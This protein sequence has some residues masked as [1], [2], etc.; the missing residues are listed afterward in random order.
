M[1]NPLFVLYYIYYNTAKG[2]YAMSNPSP[3]TY[4][5]VPF[6][7]DDFSTLLAFMTPLW[8]QTYQSILPEKQIDFLIEKYFTPSAIEDYVKQGYEYYKF[9]D[10]N[11]RTAGVLV[12]VEKAEHTFMDKLYLLPNAR[13]KGLPTQAFALMAKRGKDILL[14]VNRANERAFC[15]YRKN[16]FTV[17][18]ETQVPLKNGMVNLDY[19]MRKKV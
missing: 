17:E 5:L 4:T 9:Q 19:I 13:G 12:F 15:A 11:G 16:G 10:E 7:R 1:P 18:K 6:E 2:F 8:K 3:S 14:S